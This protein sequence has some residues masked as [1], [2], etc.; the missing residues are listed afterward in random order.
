MGKKD[1]N[2]AKSNTKEIATDSKTEYDALQAANSSRLS[3]LDAANTANRAELAGLYRGM[4]GPQGQIS[5]GQA[6]TGRLGQTFNAGMAFGSNGGFSPE[7]EASIMSNVHG[8][9]EMGRTGGLNDADAQ[10][11]RANGT[12]DEFNTTGG[13]TDADK[14]RIRQVS[15]A[16]ISGYASQTQ[17]EL[18]RRQAVQ[19]G[20]GPGFDSAARAL[21]RDA[22][23]GM[24]EAGM[25]SEMNVKD[26]VNQGRQW[27]AKGMTD[28]ENQYQTLKTGNQYKGLMGASDVETTLQDTIS[29]YRMAGYS[30]AQASAKAIADVDLSNIGNNMA[31]QQF[32]VGQAN[33]GVQGLAG[34]YNQDFGVTENQRQRDAGILGDE[35][36]SQTGINSQLNE[37]LMSPTFMQQLAMAGVQGLAGA[38]GGALT[39]GIGPAVGA[40]AKA[41]QNIAGGVANPAL[42]KPRG[43]A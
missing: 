39:G 43:Y 27:G 14:E 9:Q 10:R 19:G 18:N 8:L 15:L 22:A 23:K 26:A 41:G 30:L 13:Y 16:P 35:Y 3:Q 38:A 1:R 25:A 6:D 5:A 4:G 40:A 12:Y 29:K 2:E 17:D 21:R 32:N 20:Y 36:A 34:L 7:R 24:Y 37:I 28:A 42:N 33:S 31:A 11:F